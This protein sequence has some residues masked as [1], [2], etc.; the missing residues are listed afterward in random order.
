[1]STLSNIKLHILQHNIVSND[2]YWY[3][4]K[5]QLNVS[6]LCRFGEILS[7]WDPESSENFECFFNREKKQMNLINI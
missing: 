6:N 2:D 5:Q 3:I 7:R 4:T 1:M